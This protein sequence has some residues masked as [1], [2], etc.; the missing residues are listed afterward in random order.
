M[1][2]IPFS[3][4]FHRH[5]LKL[6]ALTSLFIIAWHAPNAASSGGFLRAD[7]NR[8]MLD[9]REYRA[10]GVNIPHLSQA[11]MGT[12]FH[13]RQIYGGAAQARQA[14]ID[15]ITDASKSKVAFVRFFAGPGYPIDAQK[16]YLKDPEQY[17]KLMD[18]L[19]SLCRQNQVK[20]VPCL[21]VIDSCWH[22]LF[23]EPRQAILDPGSKTCA[24]TRRYVRE[25]V[26]RYKNDPSILMWELN[27]EAF[28]SADVNMTGRPCLSPQV[29]PD[30]ARV[31]QKLTLKDSL[32]TAMLL[33]IYKGMTAYIKELD[34][35]HLVTSGAA[36]PRPT[37]TSLRERFPDQVWTKD[38]MRQYLS[39]LL[40]SQPEPLDV[41]SL[42]L[43]GSFNYR[44]EIEVHGLSSLDL[45][46]CLIR[47]VHASSSPLF[48]GELGQYDPS[49]KSDPQTRWLCDAIDEIENEKVSLT[50]IWCWH[51]SWQPENNITSAT[52]PEL[53]KRIAQFNRKYA[54]L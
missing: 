42:H 33:S 19:V 40:A 52:H 15:A 45:C 9:S 8:L 28:L 5:R 29:F 49:P 51:F 32:T 50:A 13:T 17:W 30:G 46:R 47:A 53:I 3:I 38:T 26:S 10:I 4:V 6:L 21:E 20:L 23:Q 1:F 44:P 24:A 27:N 41:F 22:W 37:S 39:D 7:G 35:H 12:W 16:L 54:G 31:P 25:F 18:D 36:G 43:Y 2:P 11:Y 14:M 34:P 48:I